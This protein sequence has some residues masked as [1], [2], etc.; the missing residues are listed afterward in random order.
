M[1]KKAQLQSS[2]NPNTEERCMK[3][4]QKVR[5]EI[6]F[7]MK[8]IPCKLAGMKYGVPDIHTC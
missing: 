5:Y 4:F 2:K 1:P 3:D 6:M 7:G 8:F